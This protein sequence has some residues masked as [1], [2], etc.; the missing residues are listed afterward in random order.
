MNS[1]S[2]VVYIHIPKGGGT[3]LSDW[4]YEQLR[5]TSTEMHQDEEDGWLNSGVFYYSSGYVRGPYTQDVVRIKRILPR[6][7][8]KAVLGHCNFGIHEQL[9]RPA[10]YIT[11]LRHPVERVLSLYHFEK[12]IEAKF[13]EHQG[14]KIPADTTIESFVQSPPFKDVDN[15]QTRRISGLSPAIGGCTDAMLKQAKYNLHKHFAVVGLT[16]RFDETLVLLKQTFAWN[17]D[18]F[19]YPKNTNPGR[20]TVANESPDTIDVIQAHNA[21]DCELYH[22]A[23]ELLEEEITRRGT[24][25]QELLEEFRVKKQ[26]WYEDVTAHG[27]SLAGC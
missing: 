17:K 19:Y 5:D 23:M 27:K 7:D 8:L 25:F 15:G 2:I 20:A 9:A 10:S 24:A 16:E 18:V 26:A 3:T 14:V 6:S 22:F 11:M 1:Q 4:I 13:G 12:L 21:F